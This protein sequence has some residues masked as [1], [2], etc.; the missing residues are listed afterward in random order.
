MDIPLESLEISLILKWLRR[1]KLEKEPFLEVGC[2]DGFNLEYFSRRGMRG[3]GI[4][5]SSEALARARAK[6]L[7]GVT[8]VSGDFLAHQT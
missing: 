5:N 3:I 8:L 6:K 7:D 1:K 4:D 2:G